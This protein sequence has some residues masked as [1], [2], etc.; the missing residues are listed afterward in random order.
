MNQNREAFG[1]GILPAVLVLVG[2]LLLTTLCP[3]CAMA[4]NPTGFPMAHLFDKIVAKNGMGDYD[5]IATAFASDILG[6]STTQFDITQPGDCRI[7]YDGTGTDPGISA[8][9]VQ[10]DTRIYLG[11]QNFNAANKGV[12]AITAVGDDYV[13]VENA[14]CVVESDKTIGTGKI[15][16]TSSF[17]IANFAYSET[18]DIE[19]LSGQ[20]AYFD[21]PLIDL[22]TGVGAVTI[23]FTGVDDVVW[24]GHFSVRGEGT[25]ALDSLLTVAAGCT[26]VNLGGC[27]IEVVG[28][29][30]TYS[31]NAAAIAYNGDAG[32]LWVSARG[33]SITSTAAYSLVSSLATQSRI[34]VDVDALTG[35]AS[36]TCTALYAAA[37]ATDSVYEAD[38]H[39]VNTTTGNNGRGVWFYNS[40][41]DNTVIGVSEDSDGANW[42]DSGGLNNNA[43]LRST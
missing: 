9:T 3:R 37:G 34:R 18:A 14:A 15:N 38:I 42:T 24:S 40:P 11:A 29:S 36:T 25:G 5:S 23:D 20:R 16:K 41:D 31:G 39:G 43:A 22:G 12:F 7:T 4:A 6:D 21:S 33:L 10:D 35:S 8:R 1:A 19:P 28:H 2:L 17:L 27:R 26:R 32:S 13:E 30:G